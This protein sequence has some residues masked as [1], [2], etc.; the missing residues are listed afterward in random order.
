MDV[1]LNIE[2]KPKGEDKQRFNAQE[3]LVILAEIDSGKDIK[4]A[5]DKYN[6]SVAAL[7]RWQ[8]GRDAAKSKEDPLG[9][10]GLEDES[11]RPKTFGHM[12]KKATE[13]QIID[14]WKINPGLGPTQIRNQLKREGIKASIKAIRR[15][16]IEHGYEK[17]GKRPS[18]DGLQRFEAERPN[19]LWQLDIV[20]FYISKLKLHLMLILDDRS[21]FIVGWG[22]FTEATMKSAITVLKEAIERYGKPESLL[23]DRGMQFYSWKTINKFQKL[24]ENLEIEHVLARPHHPQTLG[25]VEAL[26]KKIQVELIEKKRFHGVKETEEAIGKWIEDYNYNRTHQG[27]VDAELGSVLV[28]AD[29]YFGREEEV[30]KKVRAKLSGKTVEDFD[31]LNKSLE[32]V[33]AFEVFKI[34]EKKEVL[35]F[36][37]LGKRYELKEA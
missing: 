22:L 28:P 32:S 17:R 1:K 35:E 5:A 2:V 34:L 37:L 13:E 3:K 23:T 9:I 15:V 24:L 21:R 12:L 27:L 14:C 20:D 16:M 31:Y 33:K 10:K 4:E 8:S 11:T 30:L 6:L 19:K 26:N 18:T 7:K 36:W 29:R 25:K